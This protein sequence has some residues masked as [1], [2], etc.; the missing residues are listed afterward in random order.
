MKTSSQ[1]ESWG[2]DLVDF[3]VVLVPSQVVNANPSDSQVYSKRTEC[4][5]KW[6]YQKHKNPIV[7][8]NITVLTCQLT[9]LS[10]AELDERWLTLSRRFDLSHDILS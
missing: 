3:Q 5:Q 10:C 8:K 6:K 7:V 9:F 4:G 2:G 1:V